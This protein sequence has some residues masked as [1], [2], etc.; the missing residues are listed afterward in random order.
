MLCK[1]FDQKIDPHVKRFFAKQYSK[2]DSQK[3]RDL[4]YSSDSV[5]KFGQDWTQAFLRDHKNKFPC[6]DLVKVKKITKLFASLC[7]F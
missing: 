2:C 6:V 1:N 4:A 5:T 7:L 3:S